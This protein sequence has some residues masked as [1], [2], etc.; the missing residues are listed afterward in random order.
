[1]MMKVNMREDA[2]GRI[3][4][5]DNSLPLTIMSVAGTFTM[6]AEI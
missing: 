5:E 4:K 1:M 6:P 3:L 2:L